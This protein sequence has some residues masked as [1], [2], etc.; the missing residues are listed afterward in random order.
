[1]IWINKHV[2]KW[3]P[4]KRIAKKIRWKQY[5]GLEICRV[6][7]QFSDARIP[8]Y[9]VKDTTNK[10]TTFKISGSQIQRKYL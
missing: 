5:T 10:F 1:M 8:I 9:S 6:K 2:L 7:N 4:R 3:N